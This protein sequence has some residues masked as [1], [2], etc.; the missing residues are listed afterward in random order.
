MSK[1]QTAMQEL[2][3]EFTDTQR[4]KCKTAQEVLFFDGV[5]AII[6]T[7]YLSKERKQIEEAAF[8][9][10]KIGVYNSSYDKIEEIV[11]C[12]YS[13]AQKDIATYYTQT[14][15]KCTPQS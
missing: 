1:K 8:E 5:L 9:G 4:N 6:E 11:E 15:G 3:A 14:Y 12:D 10:V 13:S 7:K 2:I